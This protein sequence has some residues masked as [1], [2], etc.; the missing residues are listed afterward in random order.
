MWT[1]ADLMEK[2]QEALHGTYWKSFCVT[3]LVVILG[4][5]ISSFLNLRNS[6]Y[7]SMDFHRLMNEWLWLLLVFFTLLPILVGN[8]TEVGEKHFFLRNHFKEARFGNLFYGFRHSYKNLLIAQLTTS[9]I[10]LLW[11][12]LFFIPG[13]VVGYKYSMVPY[14]LSENPDMKGSDARA[15]SARMTQGQKVRILGLDLS[16]LGLFLVGMLC[17]MVGILFVKPYYEATKAE[18]YLYLRDGSACDSINSMNSGDIS[19]SVEP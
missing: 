12:L 16:F 5:N 18:L 1:R 14:L 8:I 3:S 7:I 15:L 17:L 2:A 19:A 9:V 11:S 6:I 13:I 10:I 4:L